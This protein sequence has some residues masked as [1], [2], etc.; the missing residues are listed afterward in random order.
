MKKRIPIVITVIILAIVLSISFTACNAKDGKSAYELAVEQGFEGTLQEWLDS[1][2]GAS[3]EDGSD[4]SDGKDGMNG[5]DGSDGAVDIDSLYQKAVDEGYSGSYLD[6]IKDN[7]QVNAD[8]KVAASK[9]LLS[10][11]KVRAAITYT[12]A[13]GREHNV[14][15]GG[16]GVIYKLNKEAGSAYI[17]T[18]YHVVY[19]YRSAND[20]ISQDIKVFI[21][22]KESS[23]DAIPATY[24]GGAYDYDIAILEVKD[25]DI[26]KNSDV[27]AVDVASSKDMAVGSTVMAVGNPSTGSVLEDFED[28]KIS[29][30]QGVLSVD[31]EYIS[32]FDSS[33]GYSINVR[34]M[35]VDAAINSGNS[36][37]GLY[38]ADGQLIGIVNAKSGSSSIENMGYAIP[39]DVVVGIADY[40][41]AH[42]NGRDVKYVSKCSLGLTTQSVSSKAEYDAYSQTT[43]LVESISVSAIAENSVAKDLVEI[44][45][46]IESIEIDGKE[47]AIDREF[48]LDNALWKVKGTEKVVLNVIRNSQSL[49][50]ELNVTGENFVQLS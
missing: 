46:I 4:G 18:N 43:K 10:A 21:Y 3:G 42:C 6:F 8:S 7:F 22:G 44:G 27:R 12:D 24:I 38:N 5:K 2:K 23:G 41:V 17:I 37:G 34:T 40:A 31:S 25:S 28:F 14:T 30:T 35:R 45:D 16:S 39:S 15:S 36:G 33:I 32:I 47:Y 48:A 29:I 50:L 26:I 19:H 49:V 11:V 13:I 1:L 9:A 20:G